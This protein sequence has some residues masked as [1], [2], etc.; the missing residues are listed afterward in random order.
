[1]EQKNNFEYY[2][3]IYIYIYAEPC[4]GKVNLLH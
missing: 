1:M 4:S 3:Y 2:I